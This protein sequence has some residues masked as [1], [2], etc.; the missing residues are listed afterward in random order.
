MYKRGES[1]FG[2]IKPAVGELRVREH[3]LYRAVYCGL[4]RSMG[5]CTGCLSRMSLSYDFVFLTLVRCALSDDTVQLLRGRCAAHPLKPRPYLAD[6]DSLCYSAGASALL[7]YGK[8]RD[9]VSDERGFR[10]MSARLLGPAASA[11]SRRANMPELEKAVE[12]ELKRLREL[13]LSQ[14]GDIDSAADCFGRLLGEVASHGLDGAKKRIA[15]EVGRYTG[16]FIYIIDAADDMGE[17]MRRGRYNPFLAAYGNGILEEREVGD[18]SGNSVR[19]TVPKKDV[20]ES[21]LTAAR[22]DL[23]GLERA[24]CLIPYGDLQTDGMVRG[25]IGNI[26]GM[27]MPGEMMRV[28]GL[29]PVKETK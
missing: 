25:V 27:G 28:L 2:Y 11:A 5:K 15:Y 18:F 6:C 20:A 1:V 7:T 17:D 16:R 22:L 10:R 12:G 29:V 13:E 14:S 9:D 19:R 26:I 23:A 21:I 8:I 4:C 24:E 3:E